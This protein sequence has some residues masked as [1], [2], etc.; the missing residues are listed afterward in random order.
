VSIEELDLELSIEDRLRLS[1]QLIQ[2]RFHHRS[3]AA[4]VHIEAVRRT[5][6]LSGNRYAETH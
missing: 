2:P 5:W 1:N 6:R 4:V 3:V